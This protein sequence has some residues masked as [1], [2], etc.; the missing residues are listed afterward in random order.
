MSWWSRTSTIPNDDVFY[1]I[2]AGF[3]FNCPSCIEY[4]EKI[5][6]NEKGKPRYKREKKPVSGRNSTFRSRGVCKDLLVTILAQIRT[7]LAKSGRY[8][9]I[10][11]EESV[12]D[13]VNQILSSVSFGDSNF[14]LIVFQKRTNMTDTEAFY[15]YIRNA[16]AHGS[17][18][19][20]NTESGRFYKLES[21]NDGCIKAQVRVKE[22]SLLQYIEYSEMSSADVKA[23]QK[24]KAKKSK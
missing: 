13:K 21:A 23:L 15:Y 11:S 19:V 24:P 9:L 10:K 1:S 17:F 8:A 22:S 7:P 20:I 3:V 14:E 6:V 18:E 5:G 12:E 16:F 4:K 2:I